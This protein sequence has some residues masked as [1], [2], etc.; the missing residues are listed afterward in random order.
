MATLLHHENRALGVAG[1]GPDP[2]EVIRNGFVEV[3]AKEIT[4]LG[5]NSGEGVNAA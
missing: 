4:L 1:V 2:H 5:G 3:A